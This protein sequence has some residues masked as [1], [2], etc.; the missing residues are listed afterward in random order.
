MISQVGVRIVG[1]NETLNLK[2][3]KALKTDIDII[4]MHRSCH[5]GLQNAHEGF[6]TPIGVLRQF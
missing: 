5:E 6:E 2:N 4:G 3:P 1:V